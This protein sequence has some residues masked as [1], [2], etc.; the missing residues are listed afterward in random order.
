MRVTWARILAALIIT[1]AAGAALTVAPPRAG[2]A[3]APAMRTMML[4]PSVEMCDVSDFGGLCMNRSQGGDN[5]GDAIIS[6]NPGDNNN[7][8]ELTYLD[9]MCGGSGKV[10]LNCPYFGNANVNKRFQGR[11]LVAIVGAIDHANALHN[12]LGINGT[13]QECPDPDGICPVSGGCTAT[14]FVNV[15]CTQVFACDVASPYLN[16]YWTA[17]NQGKTGYIDGQSWIK[18]PFQIGQR[19]IIGYKS[20]QDIAELFG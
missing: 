20:T 5:I 16:R 9:L 2:A 7:D 13:Q 15:N 1:A 18:I 12:C 14:I 3:A 4:T 17:G 6:W 8:F 19:I 10:T 11:V